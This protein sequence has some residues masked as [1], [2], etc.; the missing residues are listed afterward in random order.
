M[1]Q[2]GYNDRTISHMPCCC[3]VQ[4]KHWAIPLQTKPKQHMP[5]GHK[6]TIWSISA[7]M[8]TLCQPDWQARTV[9]N[10][11][12][13]RPPSCHKWSFI[14]CPS[15][16]QND[17][18]HGWKVK[19]GAGYTIHNHNPDLLPVCLSSSNPPWHH[20]QEPQSQGRIPVQASAMAPVR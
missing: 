1:L 16:R 11:Q 9:S 10:H 4:D 20:H 14:S 19:F 8:L 13:S 18:N 3:Q 7:C 17:V 2:V 12:A 6:Q 15:F 5:T